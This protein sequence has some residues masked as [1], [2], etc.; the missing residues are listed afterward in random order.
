MRKR[1]ALPVDRSEVF[2]V[3]DGQRFRW[4]IRRYG[5]VVVKRGME[6]FSSAGEARCAG[7]AALSAMLKE[8]AL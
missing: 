6:L 1:A 3:R 2:V 4:E 8:A 7:E 5:G